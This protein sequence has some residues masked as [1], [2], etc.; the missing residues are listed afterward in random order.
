MFIHVAI[1]FLPCDFFVSCVVIG[2]WG[3]SP[4]D[5]AKISPISHNKEVAS[6]PKNMNFNGFRELPSGNL[7]YENGSLEIVS[8]FSH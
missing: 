2:D 6:F 7:T 4:W 8:E 5:V 1:V 3:I